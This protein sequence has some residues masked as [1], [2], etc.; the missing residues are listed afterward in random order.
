MDSLSVRIVDAARA[1]D[2]DEVVRLA[3]SNPFIP[4]SSSVESALLA[5]CEHGQLAVVRV[6]VNELKCNPNC[7]DKAGRSPLHMAVAHKRIGK[8]AVSIIKFLVDNGAKIRKSVL[9]VCCNDFAVFPLIE[10]KADVNA[11]SVDGL[12]AVAVAISADRQ[13]VV[14]ELIRAKCNLD[15]DLIFRARSAFVVKELIRSGLDVNER[16]ACSYTPL[17]Y[18]VEGHEKRLARS[19][20][21]AK[22][23][24][25][26]VT[27]STS[28]NTSHD[29][30]AAPSS[31]HSQAVSLL[32]SLSSG[33]KSADSILSMRDLVKRVEDLDN[34]LT[35]A[36]N[37]E[38]MQDML[39]L[40]LNEWDH[41]AALMD[42]MAN[43][44]LKAIKVKITEFNQQMSS[45]N[46]RCVVCKER[47]KSVVFLPCKHMCCCGLC[48]TALRKGGS[49]EEPG[50]GPLPST[51]LQPACPICR[52]VIQDSV[53]VY[54]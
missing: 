35:E 17:H 38:N 29:S 30:E 27:R 25:S 24:P 4:A 40:D 6:C 20:L 5:A 41:V 46:G 28:L 22:A 23:D 34:A 43:H 3:K 42:K 2:G 10:L 44:T 31:V 37:T 1:G 7:V 39:S 14:G 9:H 18:A 8:V 52:S 50:E 19:L 49:W 11:K 15:K 48:A 36:S 45:S 32:R 53:N 51:V 47:Q 54:T 26:M 16:D 13:E 21:E 12:T 33:I